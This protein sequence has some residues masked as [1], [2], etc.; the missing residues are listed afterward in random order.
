MFAFSRLGPL[1]VAASLVFAASANAAEHVSVARAQ[2]NLRSGPGTQHQ[3][4]W[5]LAKG[6]PLLV[7]QRKGAWLQVRDVDGDRGWVYRSLTNKVPHHVVKAERANLRK[8]P[9]THHTKITTLE[10]GEV[11]RT[12]QKTTRWVKVETSD[13]LKGWVARS[14]LWGW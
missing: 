6:Y 4:D 11:L 7:L 10:Q 14:L 2:V 9:G 13:G 5:L 1:W 3:A 8:G 12:R